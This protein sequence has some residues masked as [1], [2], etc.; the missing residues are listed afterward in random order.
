[1]ADPPFP[2]AFRVCFLLQVPDGVFTGSTIND[3]LKEQE[4]KK[5]K[6]KVMTE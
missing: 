1:M 6:K 5:E 4:E 3:V 2:P